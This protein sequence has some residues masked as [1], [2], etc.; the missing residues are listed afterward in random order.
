MPLLVYC[1]VYCFTLGRWV[2][3]WMSKWVMNN[4]LIGHSHLLISCVHSTEWGPRSINTTHH[5]HHHAHNSHAYH[6][7]YHI[8]THTMVSQLTRAHKPKPKYLHTKDIHPPHIVLT[9]N[10]QKRHTYSQTLAHSYT[11]ITN[12]S[13]QQA[14]QNQRLLNNILLRAAVN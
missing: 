7:L 12:L 6:T 2:V 10:P 3:R 5:T 9:H 8:L 13:S 4:L 14:Q 11:H 1:L